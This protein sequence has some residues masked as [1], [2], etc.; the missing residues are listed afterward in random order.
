MQQKA[1]N[2]EIRDASQWIRPLTNSLPFLLL[3]GAWF[4]MLPRLRQRDAK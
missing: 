2:I 1:V 3:L 4:V